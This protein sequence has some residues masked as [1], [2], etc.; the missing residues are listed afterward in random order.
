MNIKLNVHDEQHWI[1]MEITFTQPCL[2]TPARRYCF[3]EQPA[4]TQKQ[5]KCSVTLDNSESNKKQI[6][7]THTHMYT[8]NW[9]VLI[10]NVSTAKVLISTIPPKSTHLL[11]KATTTNKQKRTF[12]LRFV[13]ASQF[14]PSHRSPS[15]RQQFSWRT[16]WTFM[17]VSLVK[18]LVTVSAQAMKALLDRG[19]TPQIRLKL[20][21]RGEIKI[22][23]IRYSWMAVS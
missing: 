9:M 22:I 23:Y 5:T 10:Q 3:H 2:M 19:C 20:Q 13:Y 17:T 18:C 21:R 16:A 6:I 8:Q 4:S 11:F 1:Q 7:H 15:I 14:W 12:D